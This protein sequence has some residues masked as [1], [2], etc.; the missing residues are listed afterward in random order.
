MSENNLKSVAEENVISEKFKGKNILI[1]ED[2]FI[3]SQLI[4]KILNKYIMVEVVSTAEDCFTKILETEYSL[5][6]M[7]INLGYGLSGLDAVK[8][9]R[10]I[11]KYKKVPIIATT[12]SAMKG[13][14]EEFSE[15]GFTHCLSKPFTK[16]KMLKLLSEIKIQD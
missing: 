13:D 10:S 1:V 2:D 5:I 9:I 7:D 14:K 15:A 16:E 4:C 11:E 3:S 6:F 12:A 8:H